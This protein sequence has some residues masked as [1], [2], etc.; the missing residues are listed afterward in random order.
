M[1]SVDQYTGS[2]WPDKAQPLTLPVDQDSGLS[3][4]TGNRRRSAG[5]LLG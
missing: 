1:N 4:R 2:T 3:A 5:V